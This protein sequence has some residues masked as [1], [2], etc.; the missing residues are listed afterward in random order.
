MIAI[1]LAV[2][3]S[4]YWR[5]GTGRFSLTLGRERI[6][7]RLIRQLEDRKIQYIV[8]TDDIDAMASSKHVLPPTAGSIPKILKA[9]KEKWENHSRAALLLGDTVYSKDS[10]D[11]ILNSTND[12]KFY[13]KNMEVSAILTTKMSEIPK[14]I[15]C[16]QEFES[17]NL[18]DYTTSINT[19]DRYREFV[20][21]T[22]N[23]GKLDDTISA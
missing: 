15:E 1:I 23:A 14:I 5:W 4:V 17:I 9:S 8:A 22:I 20:K 16:H 7:E 18:D 2:E 19:P 6:I 21:N 10:L 13:N 3:E 12:L 11:R